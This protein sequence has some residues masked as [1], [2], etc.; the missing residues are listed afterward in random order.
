MLCQQHGTVPLFHHNAM[1]RIALASFT[2][3]EDALK[4]QHALTGYVLGNV[5][6]T[7]EFIP[8]IEACRH[9]AGSSGFLDQS[10]WSDMQ[11]Q[12]PQHSAAPVWYGTGGTASNV[13]NMA[14]AAVAASNS[15]VVSGL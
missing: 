10:P 6:L 12:P 15:S 8:D 4:A 1:A 5:Q 13:W 14:A 11:P 7:A 2:R 3:P 9:V